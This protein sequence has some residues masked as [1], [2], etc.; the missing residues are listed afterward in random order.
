MKMWDF[1]DENGEHYWCLGRNKAEAR[2]DAK[3]ALEMNRKYN[4]GKKVINLRR[5][6]KDEFEEMMAREQ[7]GKSR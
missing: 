2:K 5:N 6:P 4:A 7:A 1:E 3:R